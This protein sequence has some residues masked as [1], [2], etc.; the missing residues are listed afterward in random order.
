MQRSFTYQTY[1]IKIL[2]FILFIFYENLTS[3][4]LFL[5]PLL[6]FLYIFM[7][8]SIKRND[9]LSF[10]FIIIILIIFEVDKGLVP[11]S[12]IIYFLLLDRFIMPKVIQNF[13]CMTCINISYVLFVYFGFFLFYKIIATIFFI[14]P[15]VFNYHTIY[16]MFIEFLLLSFL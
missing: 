8:D 10:I 12:S 11:F 3:I 9:S 15:L 16:Y 2:L 14:S 13:S 5:P 6:T 4:Y 1:S 7:S